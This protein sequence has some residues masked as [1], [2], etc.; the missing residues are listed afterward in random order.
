MRHI[1]YNGEDLLMVKAPESGTCT[2]CMYQYE[3][4]TNCPLDPDSG[5]KLC[6]DE[7]RKDERDNVIFTGDDKI[8]INDTPEALADYVTKTLEGTWE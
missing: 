5:V 7:N 8:F 2:G 6:Y 4:S 1:T 3:D